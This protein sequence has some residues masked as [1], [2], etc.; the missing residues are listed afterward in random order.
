DVS[1]ALKVLEPVRRSLG[2][3]HVAADQ[4]IA[5]VSIVGVGMRS[6]PG[7]AARMFQVLA[8]AGVNIEMIS[9]S[10]I[11]I[12]CAVRERAIERAVRML[13]RAFELQK[14]PRRR[15]Q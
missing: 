9:T 7:V 4:G 6:H 14:P 5:K 12:S 1:K 8:K 2:A 11:K 10:E 13:H 3:T 15:G